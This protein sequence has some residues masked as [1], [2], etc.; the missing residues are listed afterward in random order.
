VEEFEVAIGGLEEK[1]TYHISSALDGWIRK[2]YPTLGFIREYKKIDYAIIDST[3]DGNVAAY[4]QVDSAIEVKFNYARQITEIERRVPKGLAQAKRY[5]EKVGARASYL[6]Y[7][8]AAPY[9]SVIPPERR[10]SGWG[11]WDP[12]PK[13][14]TTLET[15]IERM[16]EAVN[17]ADAIL[18]GSASC[19]STKLCKF[20]CGLVEY[21]DQNRQRSSLRD[22]RPT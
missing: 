8:I 5:R 4:V 9:A 1:A 11:Y 19:K 17:D 22:S 7:F 20:Y 21:N 10:D 12:S 16:A 13:A 2:Y 18:I 6:L 15:A 14:L 3:V